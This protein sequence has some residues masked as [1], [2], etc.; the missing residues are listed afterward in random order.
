MHL[1][2][3]DVRICEDFYMRLERATR[4]EGSGKEGNDENSRA[5]EVHNRAC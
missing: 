1:T 3:L 4:G 2:G 5:G